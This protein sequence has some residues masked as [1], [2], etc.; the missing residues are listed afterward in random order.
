MSWRVLGKRLLRQCREVEL[1]GRCAELAYYFLFAA[2]PLLIFLTAVLGYLAGSSPGLYG[3]LFDYLE[4][5]SPS[6]QVT[7]LLH[8]TLDEVT[9]RRGGAK[10]SLSLGAALWVASSGMLAVTRSLNRACGRRDSRPWWL[11]RLVAI[12][13]T[14]T[15]IALVIAAL[16]LL[17]YGGE[18][19]QAVAARIGLGPTFVL[20]WQLLKWPLSIVFMVLSFEMIYNYGPDLGSRPIRQ[21]GTP[22]AVTGVALWLGASFGLRLY[23][24]Y[25]RSY[26]TTYGSLGAVILLLLWFYLTAFALLIGGE[27]NCELTTELAARRQAARPL[28]VRRGGRRFLGWLRR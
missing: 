15:F 21:W 1:L 13:L 5:V 27:V 26:S 24:S 18:M 11:R 22:G 23:L 28:R 25:F 10:L 19:G 14:A 12:V 2:F 4:R 8:R 16:A 9:R 17:L 20:L 3:N 6:P 7:A